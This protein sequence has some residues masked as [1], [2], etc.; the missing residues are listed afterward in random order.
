MKEKK[1]APAASASSILSAEEKDGLARAITRSSPRQLVF[2]FALW[3]SKA[4]VMYVRKRYRKTICRRTARRYLRGLGFTYQCPVRRAREQNPESVR[5]WLEETYPDIKAEAA[6]LG[7]RVFRADESSVR[8]SAIKACGY[9]PRG[10]APVL[11]APANRAVRC[12]YIAAVDNRGE[13]FFQT[14]KGFVGALTEE[15]ASPVSL[16]VDNLKVYH[17]AR[18]EK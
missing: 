9:S 7:A 3:F 16:V 12:N 5:R 1:R 10:V 8:A 6:E 4:V 18:L 14:F 17:A 13:M 2:G 15:T 11:D